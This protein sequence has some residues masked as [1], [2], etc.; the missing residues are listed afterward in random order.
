MATS[1]SSL[2]Q[3]LLINQNTLD[4]GDI[5][6]IV[7]DLSVK[8]KSFT[9]EETRNATTLARIETFIDN[10]ISSVVVIL[11]IFPL[12]NFNLDVELG[13]FIIVVLAVYFA[14]NAVNIYI[15]MHQA[16]LNNRFG[17]PFTNTITKGCFWSSQALFF[18]ALNVIKT[19]LF[20][21]DLN[22]IYIVFF[23]WFFIGFWEIIKAELKNEISPKPKTT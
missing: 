20:G 17:V 19:R 22:P 9:A 18:Y 3:S 5:A 4:T 13:N 15:L 10:S 6:D 21:L 11:A 1:S 8:S 16:R 12:F 23:I 2:L 7:E 14:L